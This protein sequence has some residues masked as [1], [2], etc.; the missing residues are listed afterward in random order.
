MDLIS[1]LL[2]VGATIIT[3]GAQAYI[4]LNYKKYKQVL[5]KSGN[6][7]FDVAREM[8]AS[9]LLVDLNKLM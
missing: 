1:I 3:G 4:S 9:G 8:K 2:I 6:T 7:G 5:I